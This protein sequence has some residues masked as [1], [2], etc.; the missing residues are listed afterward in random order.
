MKIAIHQPQYMPW[1]GYFNKMA[2]ADIF[3]L[4][5]TVQYKKNEWQNR[6]RI[7]TAQGW[8]WLTV[9][10][11]FKFPEKINEVRINGRN[12]WQSIHEKSL[13]TNY[14]KSS[15]FDIV[16]KHLEEIYTENWDFLAP[17]NIFVVKKL[18]EM[19][20]ITTPI[21]VASELDSF[22]EDPDERLI[23]ITK[24]FDGTTYLAGEG[25]QSYMKIE[26]YNQEGITVE[27][28]QYDH[29]L[30]PQLFGPFEPCLS[31]LDLLMNCGP[32]SLE[33]LKR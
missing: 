14:S 31:V 33:I 12:N 19:L 6:N 17:L 7:K 13:T 9:P 4:L 28:L 20:G 18:A 16:I 30:Y 29:P 10:V 5:D 2:T 3:I 1:L 23:A 24:Y 25:G 21:Y 26:K 27:F 15:F 32:Q 22:P 11:S 8:Q